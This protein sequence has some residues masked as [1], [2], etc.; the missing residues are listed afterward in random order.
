[1]QIV[2]LSTL[3]HAE[4]FGTCAECG[5][6]SDEAELYRIV[7]DTRAG[8]HTYHNSLCLCGD[9]MRTLLKQIKEVLAEQ[10]GHNVD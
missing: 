1:M 3:Q 10:D 2:K 8:S 5:K 9:C 7:T 6:N 4:R